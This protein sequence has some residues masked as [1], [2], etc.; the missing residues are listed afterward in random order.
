MGAAA[1]CSCCSAGRGS[2]AC[3]RGIRPSE[4][5][6]KDHRQSANLPA[7]AWSCG[8]VCCCWRPAA[9][10]LA[11]LL[12]LRRSRPAACAAEEQKYDRPQACVAVTRPHPSAAPRGPAAPVTCDLHSPK[13]SHAIV[14][15]EALLCTPWQPLRAH[16]AEHTP[17]PAAA[18]PPAND[19]GTARADAQTQTGLLPPLLRFGRPECAQRTSV[20][21]GRFLT[22]E[23]KRCWICAAVL[24][25]GRPRTSVRGGRFGVLS[26]A[27]PTPGQHAPLVGCEESIAHSGLSLVQVA[28][29]LCLVSLQQRRDHR[30]VH[31]LRTLRTNQGRKRRR[32]GLTLSRSVQS[33]GQRTGARQRPWV[34]KPQHEQNLGLVVQGKPAARREEE[35]H[36][37]L[38]SAPTPN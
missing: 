30:V 38:S 19:G 22:N 20:G 34:P 32:C 18:A 26:S 1:C 3:W 33:A 28:V 14:S 36:G 4:A 16:C 13:N 23:T 9:R 7:V 37:T 2:P 35:R 29:D 6:G 11:S 10:L 24:R 21:C 31:I 17:M 27:P 15:C 12:L 25:G 8:T 5:G